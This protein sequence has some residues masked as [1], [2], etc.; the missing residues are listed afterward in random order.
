MKYNSRVSGSL[1]SFLATPISQKTLFVSSV[2][3]YCYLRKG[4]K[5]QPESTNSTLF[6]SDLVIP[7]IT[8][9]AVKPLKT[10]YAL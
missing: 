7:D 5:T 9:V 1:E 2:N 4:L 10:S 6:V 8:P 3:H